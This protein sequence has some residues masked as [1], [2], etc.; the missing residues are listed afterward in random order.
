MASEKERIKTASERR[1]REKP[2][3]TNQKMASLADFKPS[4]KTEEEPKQE[5]EPEPPKVEIPAEPC[6]YCK[7]PNTTRHTCWGRYCQEELKRECATC[8]LRCLAYPNIL[9]NK[10]MLGIV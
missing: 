3:V 7:M 5:S 9:E 1:K 8:T 4:E 2:S 10:I 6:V